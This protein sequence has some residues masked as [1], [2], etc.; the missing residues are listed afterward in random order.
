V[1]Q[2]CIIRAAL[3]SDEGAWRQLWRGY[4]DFYRTQLPEEVTRR[5]WKRILDPDSAVM[6]I[7]AEVDGQVYGFAN[8]VVHENTWEAQAVC[9]LEDLFVTPSARGHGVGSALI[10][11]LHNAMRAEGWARLYWMTQADNVQARRLY[12]RFAQ[13]DGFVR[14]VIR[15]K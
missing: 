6:C 7:V 13:A 2:H 14:Y 1:T 9:Y 8:C 5:T 4:C 3:P 12:D 11:W 15:Q 10:E